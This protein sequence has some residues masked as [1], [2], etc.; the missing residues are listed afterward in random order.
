MGQEVGELGEGL[1]LLG[2]ARERRA[3]NHY[4]QAVPPAIPERDG[5]LLPFGMCRSLLMCLPSSTLIPGARSMDEAE[6]R[7]A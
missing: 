4:A 7:A 5:T 3:N 2:G 6:R 1:R